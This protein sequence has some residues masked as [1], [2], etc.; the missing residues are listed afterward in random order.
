MEGAQRGRVVLD[1]REVLSFSSNDYL[2]LAADERVCNAAVDAIGVHGA[3]AGSARLIAGNFSP[4]E[5]LETELARWK[6]TDGALLF[7]SGYHANVG[8]LT[9]LADRGDAIFSDAL[10]HASIID[11][12]RLSRARRI[13]YPHCDVAALDALLEEDGRAHPGGNGAGHTPRRLIVTDTV[14]GMDGDI[15]PLADIVTVAKRHDAIVVVDEAHASGVLGTQG[16]GLCAALGLGQEDVPVQMGTLG[17]ALGALGAFVAG[18]RQVVSFLLQRSRPFIFTTSTPPS[19]V[20]TALAALR[21]AMSEEGTE[22][23]ARLA[24]ASKR[25][26]AG[27]ASLGLPTVGGGETP[28]VPVLVGDPHRAVRA[29]EAL[30]EQGVWAQVIRAPTVPPGTER[31]RFAFTSGHTDADVDVALAALRACRHL[32]TPEEER[33]GGR[34]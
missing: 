8:I 6:G 33:S 29:C 30:L 3:G 2:G 18:P 28:I 22:R 5:A 19:V 21:I 9:A 20:A 27:L 15:A 7:S 26:C 34:P 1:G 12:C 32:I 14:F 11:G 17:K 24:A 16:A 23:R 13:V 25:F 10:N 4:H 31:L